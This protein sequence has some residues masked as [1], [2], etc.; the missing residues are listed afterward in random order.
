ML[1]IVTQL[2]DGILQAHHRIEQ[3]I[4]TLKTMYND[5]QIMSQHIVLYKQE[6]EQ[7]RKELEELKAKTADE[8]MNFYLLGDHKQ[9][10]SDER[11]DESEEKLSA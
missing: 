6:N 4:E 5:M 8:L 1:E 9:K 2:R 10:E 7:L 11:R 3:V